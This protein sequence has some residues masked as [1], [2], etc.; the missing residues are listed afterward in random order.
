MRDSTRDIIL[1]VLLM[2]SVT[3]NIFLWLR[4]EKEV[5]KTV[6]IVK[7]DTIVDVV[8]DFDTVYIAKTK[9]KDVYKYDTLY[10]D[11]IVYLR[12]TVHN[13]QFIQPDYTLGIDAMKLVDYKLDI[14]ARDTVT[15]TNTITTIVKEKRKPLGFG[16]FAGPSYDPI[17]KSFGLSVG[18]GITFNFNK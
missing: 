4:P 15:V 11:S 1:T 8:R 6:E 7:R 12:D 18:A 13:Y 10:K 3:L 16:I 2:I 17:N 14:H 9:Y 5:E